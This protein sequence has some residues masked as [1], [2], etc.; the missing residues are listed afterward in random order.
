MMRGEGLP[1]TSVASVASAMSS[2]KSVLTTGEVARI[3]NV[4][5]RTV[6]KWFDSGQLRGYRIP[7]SKDRR[8]PRNQLLR[9]MRAHG[10]PL[11]NLETGATRL[12]LIDADA[13]FGEA[14][15]QA[16]D[17]NGSFE[18]SVA[19]NA[20]EAGAIAMEMKPHVLLADVDLPD[21]APQ[22]ITRYLRAQS[23]LQDVCLIGM[24]KG[25]AKARGQALLQEG[26]DAYLSK[27]FGVRSLVKLIEDRL[28]GGGAADEP[29]GPDGP[30]DSMEA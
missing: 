23:D 20:F 28:S 14:L 18:V 12:L 13:G 21:F 7:G 27:P 9:F 11:D 16:L 1:G 10:I 17:Q 19:A 2:R 3:C 22:A 25:L 30:K 26:F 6:S 29:A 15:K 8:I 5:P 4:A 24:A